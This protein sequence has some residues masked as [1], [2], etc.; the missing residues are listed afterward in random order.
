MNDIASWISLGVS[1]AISIGGGIG[2]A[3]LFLGKYKEKIKTLEGY[4][5]RV[6]K[7]E[8]SN[9]QLTEK[10]KQLEKREEKS[11]E[12]IDQLCSDMAVQQSVTSGLQRDIDKNSGIAQAHSPLGLTDKG[13]KLVRDSGAM[14]IY[15]TI[16]DE[17]VAELELQ[18]PRSQYD[19]QEKARWMMG[20]K[21][22]DD[23]FSQ[24][25]DWAYKNGA[26]FSQ[27]LRSLGLP[28]R[29]YYFEKHPE[30]VNP[31]ETY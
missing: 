1:I 4:K 31:K 11:N 21:F 2:A 17:L 30:I 28:L 10:V 7:L 6:E 22:D 29:D 8:T 25:E 5:E 3:A 15:D 24:V 16:K 12:K 20:Q 13:W 19:V 23:R 9:T 27:I 26:D 14:D 18:E